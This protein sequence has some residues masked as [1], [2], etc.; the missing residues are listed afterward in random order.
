MATAWKYLEEILAQGSRPIGSSANQSTA[1]WICDT[2]SGFGLDVEEQ[3]YPCTAWEHRSTRLEVGGSLLEA[4]ANAFSLS[5]DINAPLVSAASMQELE[6]VSARGKLLLV[7]GELVRAP[8]SPKS[9]FL[10]DERD[11]HFI[12]LLEM[13][14]PAAILSPP[15]NTDY[16]GQLTEDWELELAAATIPIE[17]AMEILRKPSSEVHLSI[18]AQRRPAIARN[19]VARSTHQHAKRLVLCAH[20][21]TKI[22]TPGASDN[23]GGVS[24]LLTLAGHLAGQP[25]PFDL[26]CIAFNGEEYLPVGDE[27]YLRRAQDYLG[28]ILA[29]INF[30][31]IGPALGTTSITCMGGADDLA[32][33]FHA[34]ANTHPG[35]IWVEP[36]PESNH[37]TFAMRGIPAVAFGAI[38][39]RSLAHSLADDLTVMSAA[40][41]DEAISLAEDIVH[42]FKES[43]R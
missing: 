3:P 13:Q 38:G 21:D 39:T 10:K 15:T 35:V 11:E 19:I 18:Q 2:F 7:Y 23:G 42:W 14:K 26:E 16:Y 22:N 1:D 36:W 33:T 8:L 32:E 41:L 28:N 27:E 9:W 5:C 37:S 20:F 25:M 6:T 34:L 30:D 31:G 12:H 29:C 17:V 24:A 4:T 40:K 43:V